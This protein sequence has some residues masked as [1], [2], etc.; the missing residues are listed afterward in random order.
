MIRHEIL[1]NIWGSPRC[2]TQQIIIFPNLIE[3][4]HAELCYAEALLFKAALTIIEDES[5]LS[6][7]R[8]GVKIRGC[9]SSYRECS[10]IMNQRNWSDQCQKEHF[11]G[12]V[13]MGVGTFNLVK[14]NSYKCVNRNLQFLITDG[15]TDASKGYQ[16]ARLYGICWE[17]STMGIEF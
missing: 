11:E 17:Q 2:T 15:L 1:C 16:T 9:L 6:F 13:R 5:L 10:N 14:K 3:E 7:I 12:G 8:A 4:V